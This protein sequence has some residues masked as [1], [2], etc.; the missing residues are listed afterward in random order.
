[1]RHPDLGESPRA[2]VGDFTIAAAET[3]A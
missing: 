3:A 2:R 1:V